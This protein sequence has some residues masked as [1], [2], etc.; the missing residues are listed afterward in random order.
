MAA[1]NVWR[2]Q[3]RFF[4]CR[5][6]TRSSPARPISYCLPFFVSPLLHHCFSLFRPTTEIA[7]PSISTTD[8]N[9]INSVSDSTT[10]AAAMVTASTSL[11]ELQLSLGGWTR[12]TLVG[13]QPR[14]I[15]RR[16]DDNLDAPVMF[17]LRGCSIERFASN[18]L[19]VVGPIGKHSVGNFGGA[20]LSLD[21]IH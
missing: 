12:T 4:I 14:D 7:C 10:P 8:M 6:V 11:E 3:C 21:A 9:K 20:A 2:K 15:W 18:L 16:A 17:Y 19:Q 13:L 5:C 1:D